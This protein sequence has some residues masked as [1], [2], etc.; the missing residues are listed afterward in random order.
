MDN[1]ENR[2]RWITLQSKLRNPP[3]FQSHSDQLHPLLSIHIHR[4]GAATR[5][6]IAAGAGVLFIAE[7]L[8][9][10]K[11]QAHLYSLGGYPFLFLFQMDLT[12][13][14]TSTF[15][16]ILPPMHRPTFSASSPLSAATGRLTRPR[17]RNKYPSSWTFFNYSLI[18]PT[19]SKRAS[20]ANTLSTFSR[21]THIYRHHWSTP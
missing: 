10:A 8:P 12:H 17:R 11:V 16:V 9:P 14:L 4:A 7:C 1:P 19:F 18:G 3:Y 13:A 6:G 2:Q 5:F 15:F 21:K 20:N